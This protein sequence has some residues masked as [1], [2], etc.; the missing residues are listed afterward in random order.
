MNVIQVQCTLATQE[1]ADLLVQQAL[2]QRLIA[3]AAILPAVSSRYLWKGSICSALEVKILMKTLESKF[4]PLLALIRTCSS[5]DVPEVLAF[6]VIN[7]NP[8][9]ARWMENELHS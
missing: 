5:Y 8:D 2:Q 9:Y 6:L 1:E 4:E 7:A 3:C